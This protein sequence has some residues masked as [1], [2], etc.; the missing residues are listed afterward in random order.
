[1]LKLIIASSCT[2]PNDEPETFDNRLNE[3]LVDHLRMVSRRVCSGID[4][5]PILSGRKC[6]GG[7]RAH[8]GRTEI[9][10]DLILDYCGHVALYPAFQAHL[11]QLLPPLLAA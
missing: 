2:G 3:G 9:Q 5:T 1:M 8:P 6:P 11:S 4:V 10:L 7:Y